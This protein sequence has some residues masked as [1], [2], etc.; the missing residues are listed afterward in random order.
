MAVPASID[1]YAEARALGI[2][3]L[4]MEVLIGLL[5]QVYSDGSTFGIPVTGTITATV[6]PSK[7][8]TA[9]LAN[10][11]TSAGTNVTLHVA[12]ANRLGFTIYNDSLA[13]LYV[14][15]GATASTTSFTILMAAGS[16]YELP[17]TS[18]YTG[19]IDAILASA[20]TGAARITE[21]TA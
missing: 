10:I 5:S 3:E 7:S 16:Y 12:N 8:A 4:T 20:T 15:F 21:L 9:T 13:V 19:R 11:D 2:N 1:T 6:T 14:K 18:I 17:T